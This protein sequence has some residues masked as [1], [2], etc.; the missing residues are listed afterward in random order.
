[1]L[2]SPPMSSTSWVRRHCHPY[3]QLAFLLPAA[4][5]S[6]LGP[7]AALGCLGLFLLWALWV[8]LPLKPWALRF[9]PVLSG[10]GLLAL[11]A[12]FTPLQALRLALMGIAVAAFATA[13]PFVVPLSALL[14]PL[15]RLEYARPL[16]V[17]FCF[18]AKHLQGMAARLG[19]RFWALRLRGGLQK[20][21]WRGLRLLLVGFLPELFGKADSLALAMQ[22]RGFRGVLP[23]PALP[24]LGLKDSPALFLGALAL[25]VGWGGAG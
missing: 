10:F 2:A 8:G 3:A 13:L 23:A 9:V 11:A 24:R 19:Q 21:R 5:S 1:M 22:L 17:F 25:L 4:A 15:S 7:K 14:A 12:L 18:T 20:S 16:V 6:L